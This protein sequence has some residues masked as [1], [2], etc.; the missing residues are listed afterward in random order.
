M[1]CIL[2]RP[3]KNQIKLIEKLWRLYYFK[4]QNK[5]FTVIFEKYLNF[6]NE[7]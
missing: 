6:S 5:T 1:L 3:S 4:I 2:K 7:C